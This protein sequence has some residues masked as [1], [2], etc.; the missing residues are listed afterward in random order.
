MP[1]H[2]A[3]LS[4]QPPRKQAEPQHSV[5]TPCAATCSAF[6]LGQVIDFSMPWSGGTGAG[7]KVHGTHKR[8]LQKLKILLQQGMVYPSPPNCFRCTTLPLSLCLPLGCTQTLYFCNCSS[9]P[10]RIFLYNWR[11]FSIQLLFQI[12]LNLILSL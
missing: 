4:S 5:F 11:G 9:G 7:H 10:A 1:A 2:Q 3:P 12:V 8:A 6:G